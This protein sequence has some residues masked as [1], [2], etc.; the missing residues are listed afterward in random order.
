MTEKLKCPTQRCIDMILQYGERHNRVSG[1][2]CES[3]GGIFKDGKWE[4]KCVTCKKE[5]NPGE[6]TGLFVPHLCI[7]CKEVL[8]KKERESG[9]VCSMCR[10]VYSN[11]YC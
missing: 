4:H 8:F 2:R 6:L 1:N 9:Q 7:S 3:C 5:V 10:Q 11:C